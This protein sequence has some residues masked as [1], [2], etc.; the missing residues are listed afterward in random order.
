MKKLAII[1]HI[2]YTDLWEEFKFKLL[3]LS[4][5]FDLYISLT[6]GN[7]NIE[8]DIINTFP[9]SKIFWFDNRGLDVGPFFHILKYFIE[10][11]LNYQYLIKLHTKK[12]IHSIGETKGTKWR[13]GLVYSLIGSDEILK[14]NISMFD[15]NQISNIG[16]NSNYF[17]KDSKI[18]WLRDE[19]YNLKL[20]NDLH[21][22][23]E[24]HNMQIVAGT[25]F[26]VRYEVY[27]EF[28]TVNDINRILSQLT[29]GYEKDRQIEHKLERIL[30]Y[31]P[32]LNVSKI[33]EL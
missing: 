12:S 6:N 31:I 28:F 15:I 5:D 29:S 10:N 13:N 24:F 9:H 21:S 11:D 14:K 4:V 16:G 17:H 30:S 23:L 1:L 2:Y 32:Q 26:M 20:I 8:S 18:E 22:N 3:D 27:K 7:A 33:L 19:L 25:M